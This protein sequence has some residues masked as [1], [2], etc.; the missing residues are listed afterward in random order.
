MSR[1]KSEKGSLDFRARF[2]EARGETF[3]DLL[4]TGL[5]LPLSELPPEGDVRVRY[6]LA[7]GLLL[8]LS[9]LPPEAKG[10]VRD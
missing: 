4:A 5:L 2:G 9:E 7:T 1:R 6:Q 3:L 8:P 10:N